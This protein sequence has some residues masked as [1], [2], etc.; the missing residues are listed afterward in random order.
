MLFSPLCAFFHAVTSCCAGRSSLI[1]VCKPPPISPFKSLLKVYQAYHLCTT[2]CS[3]HL[4]LKTDCS[5]GTVFSLLCL[6]ILLYA[7]NAVGQ[8]HQYMPF[9]ALQ[10]NKSTCQPASSG[11]LS[12]VCIHFVS[13][14]HCKAA[15]ESCPMC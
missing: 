8:H 11:C 2:L 15:N 5:S 9:A 4:C 10:C 3:T 7:Y 14:K 13:P 12:C 6:Y 1:K